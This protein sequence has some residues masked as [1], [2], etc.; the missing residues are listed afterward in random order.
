[1]R[2][3]VTHIGKFHLSLMSRFTGKGGLETG[4]SRPT[5]GPTSQLATQR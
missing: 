5:K 3:I 2:D 4:P 1:M